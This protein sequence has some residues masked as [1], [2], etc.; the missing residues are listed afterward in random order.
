VTRERFLNTKVFIL[1]GS[2][3]ITSTARNN[4]A[5][6]YYQLSRDAYHV[7]DIRDVSTS[8]VTDATET[9]L[10]ARREEGRQLIRS[11][12]TNQKWT[13]KRNLCSVRYNIFNVYRI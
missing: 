13:I 1:H 9:P 11:N 4:L 5:R 2:E 12:F 6:H 7:I 8:L 10:W 3:D